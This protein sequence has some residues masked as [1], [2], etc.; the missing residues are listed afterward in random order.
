MSI[1]SPSTSSAESPLHPTGLGAAGLGSVSQAA[2][3]MPVLRV[4]PPMPGRVSG[5]GGDG[6]G[7]GITRGGD[8]G[9]GSSSAMEI[10]ALGK[11]KAASSSSSS[12]A[13]SS[14]S[15][16]SDAGDGSGGGGTKRSLCLGQAE[17]GKAK[18][19]AKA[20]GKKIAA[21]APWAVDMGCSVSCTSEKVSEGAGNVVYSH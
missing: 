13:S 19:T 18:I 12:S 2:P 9:S 1:M 11:R 20:A 15:S 16:S 17:E 21:L 8:G 14:S 3:M 10:G 5:S 7:L 4:V 6:D